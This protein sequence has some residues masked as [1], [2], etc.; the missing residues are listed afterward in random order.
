MTETKD[1]KASAIGEKRSVPRH[2]PVQTTYTLDEVRARP[3][4]Q[5]VSV[6]QD[7]VRPHGLEIIGSKRLDGRLCPYR[8]KNRRVYSP[9]RESELCSP[10]FAVLVTG[11][12]VKCK[13]CQ[14]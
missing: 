3:Q 13:G 8:H 9:V 6:A 5:M 10:G 12:D 7:D 11:K 4:M 14:R 1:L 2:E